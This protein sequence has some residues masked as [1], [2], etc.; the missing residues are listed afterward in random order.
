MSCLTLGTVIAASASSYPML[1][2]G[3]AVMGLG[4]SVFHPADFSIL[5]ARVGQA[6]LGFAYSAHGV[7]GAFGYAAS[8]IFIGSAAALWGWHAAL[9]V[10]SLVGVWMLILLLFN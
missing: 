1:V 6:R 4:N 3:A 9:I 7:S 5:N 8:P 10:G 2:G